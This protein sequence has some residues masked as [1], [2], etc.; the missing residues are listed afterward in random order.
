MF[1]T[2]WWMK[3]Q[4]VWQEKSLICDPL[5]PRSFPMPISTTC[6]NSATNRGPSEPVE[7]ISY[8]NHDPGQ[9]TT[10]I[11][12]SESPVK[13][14]MFT[15]NKQPLKGVVFSSQYFSTSPAC[16]VQ[17]HLGRE[18]ESLGTPSSPGGHWQ[19]VLINRLED[20]EALIWPELRGF[21]V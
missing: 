7:Y 6:Q 14:G 20:S 19:C 15:N 2:S 12:G 9:T 4:R 18:A 5:A 3:K 10:L 21:N 8:S 13:G 17:R 1:V 11:M 16:Q